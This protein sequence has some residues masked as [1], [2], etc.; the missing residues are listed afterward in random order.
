MQ[1]E[2]HTSSQYI[3]CSFVFQPSI[4]YE[5]RFAISDQLVTQTLPY[6]YESIMHYT[7]KAYSKN[8]QYTIISNKGCV[9][10]ESL[11]SAEVPTKTD[12]MHIIFLYCHGMLY[13]LGI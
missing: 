1:N 10:N 9:S 7:A 2:E 5:S 4:G 13:F 11:G 6:D 8:D 3:I 12:F